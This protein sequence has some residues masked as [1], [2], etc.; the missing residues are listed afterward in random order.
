MSADW[1]KLFEYLISTDE[2][3]RVVNA[4]FCLCKAGVGDAYPYKSAFVEPPNL[5]KSRHGS[6]DGNHESSVSGEVQ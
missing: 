2:D 6:T 3:S 5:L 4:N 1:L